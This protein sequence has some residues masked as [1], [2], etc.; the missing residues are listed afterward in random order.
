MEST[1][2]ICSQHRATEKTSEVLPM[3]ANRPVSQAT[4]A[5]SC[6]DIPACPVTRTLSFPKALPT[7][8]NGRRRGTVRLG[9][10][11]CGPTPATPPLSVALQGDRLGGRSTELPP[12]LLG[13]S[14]SETL[15]ETAGE[16]ETL[17][18]EP[19]PLAPVKLGVKGSEMPWSASDDRDGE[20][21]R[22]RCP[23]RSDKERLE[24]RLRLRARTLVRGRKSGEAAEDSSSASVVMKHDSGVMGVP[25]P[26]DEST[27]A[28][29]ARDMLRAPSAGVGTGL[30]LGIELGR[31]DYLVMF[32]WWQLRVSRAGEMA[33]ACARRQ[34]DRLDRGGGMAAGR[35]RLTVTPSRRAGQSEAR[36]VTYAH[37][38]LRRYGVRL[39]RR[40]AP[41]A[42]KVWSTSPKA[43]PPPPLPTRVPRDPRTGICR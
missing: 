22:R 42:A 3:P 29:P 32:P 15:E 20:A 25:R 24:L 4:A 27:S 40:R 41:P 28:S 30:I 23:E 8:E 36:G 2:T 43:A 34:L 9:M 5:T 33:A 19:G 6:M 31:G 10:T 14:E 18:E 12:M 13:S 7:S 37:G 38:P 21:C 35:R 16:G 39:G 1:C 11:S 17:T 26:L